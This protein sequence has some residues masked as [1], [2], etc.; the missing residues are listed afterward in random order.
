MCVANLAVHL[1]DPAAAPELLELAMD[2][3]RW[4]GSMH[5]SA[6]GSTL[7]DSRAQTNEWSR[8]RAAGGISKRQHKS[9]PHAGVDVDHFAKLTLKEQ[10][11]PRP[12]AVVDADQLANLTLSERPSTSSESCQLSIRVGSSSKAK[13]GERVCIPFQ[14]GG[15]SR[16]LLG[17]EIAA[18][19]ISRATRD[20]NGSDAIEFV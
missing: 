4:A 17:R 5:S 1:G 18:A 8:R 13:S 10:Q 15:K 12:R 9:R 6:S 3:M 7:K 19:A 16:H 2:I 20:S 14:S 11:R